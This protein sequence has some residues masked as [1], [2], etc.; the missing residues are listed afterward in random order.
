MEDVPVFN[1]NFYKFTCD[2]S[3]TD[4]VLD[5]LKEISW[6]RNASNLIST[7]DLFFHRDLFDWFD[8]CILSTKKKIGIPDSVNLPITSCWANKTGKLSGHHK[9]IHSN[10][11]ISGIFY[12]TSHVSGETGFASPNYWLKDIQH[13]HFLTDLPE[14]YLSKILPVK[15]TLILFPSH[16]PHS[17]LALKENEDRYTISFNTYLDGDIDDGKQR[18]RLHLKSKSVRDWHNET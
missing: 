3:L 2:D 18:A 13:M 9:H 1:I 5:I 10:S 14:S 16:M 12:L 7:D 8:Q 11:V 6:K 4:Q 17:A 15:S